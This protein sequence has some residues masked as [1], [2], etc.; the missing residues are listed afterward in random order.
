MSEEHEQPKIDPW[1]EEHVDDDLYQTRETLIGRVRNQYDDQSWAEFEKVYRGYIFAII[2]KLN[3][4]Q[5]DAEDLAQQVLVKVWKKLPE[6]EVAPSGR[7]RNWLS[8]VTKN[9]VVDFARKRKREAELMKDAASEKEI[10][11][12]SK[13]RVSD[14]ERV[15]E[16]LWRKHL[17]KLALNNIEPLFSG[18]A[19]EVFQLTLEGVGDQKIAAKL[20]LKVNSVYRLRFRVKDKLIQEILRLRRE[21]E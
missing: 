21:L 17:T 5:H 2:R 12:L 6:L 3:I 19:M 8:T 11:Y 20:G 9:C 15:S 13:I 7:F 1:H 18:K 16:E 4:A 14:A 10:S